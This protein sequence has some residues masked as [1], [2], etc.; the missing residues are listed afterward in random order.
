MPVQKSLEKKVEDLHEKV[1][2]REQKVRKLTAEKVAREGEDAQKQIAEKVEARARAKLEAKDAA[3]A[4]AQ[5]A[6]EAARS[7]DSLKPSFQPEVQGLESVGA[8]RLQPEQRTERMAGVVLSS[9][10][11]VASVA[12]GRDVDAKRTVEKMP[13]T[14]LLISAEKVGVGGQS[15]KE[16]YEQ[17]RI[18]KEDLR[19][20]VIEHIRGSGKAERLLAERLRPVRPSETMEYLRGEGTSGVRQSVSQ[21]GAASGQTGASGA[22]TTHHSGTWPDTSARADAMIA[23]QAAKDA[24][25]PN[26]TAAW[27][28]VG[29]TA[30]ALVAAFLLF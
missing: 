11:F 23:Q 12:E 17:G 4:E 2:L 27:I 28:A 25:N 5:E 1:A 7:E 16:L 6:R 29:G 15:A 20:I 21:G 3:R 13:E 8:E 9:P 24:K 30:A 22:Q 14:E 10:E 19:E 18:A 26:H